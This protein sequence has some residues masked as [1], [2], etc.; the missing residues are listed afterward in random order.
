MRKFCFLDVGRNDG[1]FYFGRIESD[2]IRL[3]IEGSFFVGLKVMKNVVELDDE[4]VRRYLVGESI[5][6]DENFYGWFILK[7]CF[8]YFGL[9]KVKDGR[10]LNYVLKERRF[11]VE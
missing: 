9:V 8:Y 5:E 10:F 4:W 6:V 11:R 7:W 1:W 2:G 3:I